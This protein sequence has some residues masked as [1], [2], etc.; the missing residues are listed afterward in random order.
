[1]HHL[2]RRAT[3]TRLRA[4]MATESKEE[5]ATNSPAVGPPELQ[6]FEPPELLPVDVS[7]RFAAEVALP[8]GQG[9]HG[10]EAL[11]ALPVSL[12]CVS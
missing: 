12:K 7:W 8:Q 9:S 2:P 1:M 10:V 3:P 11:D 6:F 4:A 5:E